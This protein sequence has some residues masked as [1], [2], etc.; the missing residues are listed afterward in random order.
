MCR[1]GRRKPDRT[2]SK[3]ENDWGE[4]STTERIEDREW[5]KKVNR[6]LNKE[7]LEREIQRKVWERRKRKNEDKDVEGEEQA[8]G[9]RSRIEHRAR[10]RGYYLF[11]GSLLF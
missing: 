6:G 1:E 8:S 10:R 4:G 5:G 9:E 3:S 2:R 7:D 11:F